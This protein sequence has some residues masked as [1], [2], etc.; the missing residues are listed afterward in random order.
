[1]RE[2]RQTRLKLQRLRDNLLQSD[3]DRCPSDL[4]IF[5]DFIHSDPFTRPV[6]DELQDYRFDFSSWVEQARSERGY[7]LPP[8]ERNRAAMCLG[9]LRPTNFTGGNEIWRVSFALC[10][11]KSGSGKLYSAVQAF[12]EVFLTPLWQYI[13]E[14]LLERESMVTPSDIMLEVTQVVGEGRIKPFPKTVEALQTAYRDLYSASGK[15]IWRNVGNACR[16]ALIAFADE[17]Y[18]PSMMPA[19]VPQPKGDDA[20]QKIVLA[21]KQHWLRRSKKDHSLGALE[22]LIKATWDMAQSLLHRKDA[23]ENEAKACVMYTY[24]AVWTVTAVIWE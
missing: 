20:K 16:A 23:T 2:V 18:D 5:W 19:D 21:L 13:D 3:Q 14:R 17:I 12:F 9:M 24:L 1:M 8:D 11:D 4:G 6:V 22:K 15:V 10:L 7:S